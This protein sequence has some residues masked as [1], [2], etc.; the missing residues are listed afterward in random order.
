MG[1]GSGLSPAS[2]RPWW[3]MCDAECCSI[4][5][6]PLLALNFPSPHVR[7]IG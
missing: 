1:Q 2:M 5:R 4:G 6:V 3:A 7:E